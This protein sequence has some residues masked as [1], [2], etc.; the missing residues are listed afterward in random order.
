MHWM[1]D[2]ELK[3]LI[4]EGTPSEGGLACPKCKT[5]IKFAR[6]LQWIQV[7]AEAPARRRRA[8]VRIQALVRMRQVR[9]RVRAAKGLEQVPGAYSRPQQEKGRVPLYLPMDVSCG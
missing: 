3:K 8:A 5:P 1:L 2:W 7:A 9:E 4:R 6:K